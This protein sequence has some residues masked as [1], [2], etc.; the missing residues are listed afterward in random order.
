[1][2]QTPMYFTAKPPRC[3]GE[4]QDDDGPGRMWA[5]VA[6][7]PNV[8]TSLRPTHARCR[9]YLRRWH[10]SEMRWQE[11]DGGRSTNVRNYIHA[12]GVAARQGLVFELVLAEQLHL[13][14]A[15]LRGF[16]SGVMRGKLGAGHL[17]SVLVFLE[18][19]ADGLARAHGSP[20]VNEHVAIEQ[21]I[22]AM[23]VGGFADVLLVELVLFPWNRHGN[24]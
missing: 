8:R 17:A 6:S 4:W 9:R 19:R 2:P 14:L 11:G 20:V 7:S 13:A 12:L 10:S 16:L 3:P 24:D 5:D 23:D 1:M 22:D 18:L 21:G 15:C